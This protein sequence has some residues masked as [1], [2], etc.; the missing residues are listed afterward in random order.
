MILMKKLKIIVLKQ[1]GSYI[2][3]KTLNGYPDIYYKMIKRYNNLQKINKD[4]E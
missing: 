4:F 3:D 1:I 2:G